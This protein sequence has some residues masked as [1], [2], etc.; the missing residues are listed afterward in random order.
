MAR[1]C[2]IG[3]CC[4]RVAS[5]R[6]VKDVRTVRSAARGWACRRSPKASQPGAG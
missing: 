6:T 4:H 2:A 5:P 3:K 1:C